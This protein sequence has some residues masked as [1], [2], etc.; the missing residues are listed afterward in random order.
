MIKVLSVVGLLLGFFLAGCSSVSIIPNPATPGA[1]V[2]PSDQSI[3]IKNSGL[4]I[5]ARVQDTAVGGYDIDTAIGAFYL[6]IA[7]NSQQNVDVELAHFQL[8]DS[9]GNHHA[10]LPPEEVN[11]LLNPDIAVFLPYPFVGYYDTIDLEQHRASTAMASERPY[12]GSGLPAIDQLIPLEVGVLAPGRT[13]SGML[14]FNIEIIDESHIELVSDLP[15]GSQGKKLAFS[16]PFTI[17]K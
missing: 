10:P 4:V 12:V 6:T 15:Y 16:F 17:K 11:A 2:N 3:K 9:R 13:V 14:Y 7:N 1:V 8:V 5:S